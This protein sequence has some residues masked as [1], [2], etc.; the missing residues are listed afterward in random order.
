MEKWAGV[1]N[2]LL[3]FWSRTLRYETRGFEAVLEAKKRGPVLYVL[4]HDELFAPLYVH[5]QQNVLALVSQSRD[6]EF[7]A[8]ILGLQGYDLARGSSTRGGI[9]ALKDLLSR[10]KDQAQDVVI[11]VDGPRGPRHKVK[12][13]ALYLSHKAGIPLVP[14]RVFN[15]WVRRFNSWDRFQ[16]PWPGS[17]AIIGY[18]EP[19]FIRA[20][21]MN[22]QVLEESRLELETRMNDLYKKIALN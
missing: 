21:R 15:Q 20:A 6:G 10:I 5:R 2:C 3:G 1:V 16:L 11:T 14:V 19:Y 22:N 9:R 17:R 12:P 13:G 18:G 8:R 7:L 4:W